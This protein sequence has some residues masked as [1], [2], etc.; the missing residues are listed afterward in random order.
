MQFKTQP[1]NHQLVNFEK[2]KDEIG[3]A[4]FWEVGSGKT[5]E[6]IMLA[7]WKYNLAGKI[8]PTG[9]FTPPRPVPGWRKQWLDHS[10]IDPARVVLLQGSQSERIKTFL[11]ARAKFNDEFVFVTN[12]EALLM[13]NLYKEFLSFKPQVIIWDESHR[14]KSA[15][16]QRTKLADELSN[17][18]DLKAR[19]PL[20]KPFTYMLS[21]SPVLKDPMDLFMQFKIMDGG[22]TFGD[23]IWAFRAKYFRDRNAGMPKERYFP[24]WELMTKEKDGFDAEGELQ[25]K[26]AGLASFVAKEDCLDLPPELDEII[27]VKMGNDQERLYRE[28]K[29]DLLTFYNSKACVASLAITK[30]LRMMQILT[31]YV[32]VQN[33]GEDS[34]Q[35][36]M[37]IMDNPRIEAYKEWLE[38]MLEMGH[39]PLVW[40]VFKHN[41]KSLRIAT[42]EVFDK[43][44]LKKAYFA[45]CHG[46]I[47][48]KQQALNL[49]HFRDD[50]NCRVFL[51]H[52]KSG[53][54][55]VN[56][57]MKAGVD[58]TYSRDFNLESYIQSRGRNHRDG[59]EKFGHKKI[60]HYN[61]VTT[62][63]IDEVAHK[64]LVNKE[65]MS[66]RLLADLVNEIKEQKT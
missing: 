25:K 55:G 47:S 9:I 57:L 8:L 56:E 34:E 29:N 63:T 53:G 2:F 64:K 40:A 15:K 3:C 22:K 43:L 54:I 36:M 23:N 12:Y 45:E 30:A 4:C 1:R 50:E 14:L 33:P 28:M 17:P 6:S 49:E 18:Y 51:G 60:V 35:I 32:P 46:E 39:S 61:F 58:A 13:K 16:A 19:R 7:R 26:M 42:Q 37:D 62:G 65:D 66:D 24:K 11:A 31:G 20:P 44:K 41:Y 10:N 5:Y 38:E 48:S 21:G 27:E 59:T 52:P